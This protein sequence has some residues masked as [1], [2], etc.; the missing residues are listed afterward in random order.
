MQFGIGVWI[1]GSICLY[2]CSVILFLRPLF[3]LMGTMDLSSAAN[4]RRASD[5]EVSQLITKMTILNGSAIVSSFAS[6]IIYLFTHFVIAVDLDV[7][8]T[9]VCVIIATNKHH[10][11]LYKRLCRYDI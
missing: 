9:A 7:G 10:K 1:V 6:L 11:S 5:S 4:R 2:I 3:G 8:I